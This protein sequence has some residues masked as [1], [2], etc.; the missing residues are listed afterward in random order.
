MIPEKKSL[1]DKLAISLRHNPSS[2]RWANEKKLKI[3][4]DS[5]LSL[6]VNSGGIHVFEPREINF[7]WWERRPLVQAFHVWCKRVGNVEAAV[8]ERRICKEAM[9]LL[10]AYTSNQS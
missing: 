1:L 4:H 5:G 2:W 8:T 9:S 3:V 6:W 7:G 10:D